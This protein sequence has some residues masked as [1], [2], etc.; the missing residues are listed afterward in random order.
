MLRFIKVV[1]REEKVRALDDWRRR[2]TRV[3]CEYRDEDN[4]EYRKSFESYAE[5]IIP[6]SGNNTYLNSLG[7]QGFTS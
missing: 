7:E 6:L 5:P 4:L 1:K 3:I 2:V